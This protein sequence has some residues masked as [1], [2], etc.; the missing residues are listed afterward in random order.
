V[1]PV[2]PGCRYPALSRT[3]RTDEQYGSLLRHRGTRLLLIRRPGF[4]RRR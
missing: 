2:E 1:K 4:T 3:V